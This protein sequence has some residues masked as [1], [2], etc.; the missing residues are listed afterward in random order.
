MTVRH[1]HVWVSCT[2]WPS[3][4]DSMLHLRSDMR[5]SLINRISL[6]YARP[7]AILVQLYIAHSLTT[8][9]CMLSSIDTLHIM[10]AQH[11]A[12]CAQCHAHPMP[13]T[14]H[15]MHIPCKRH[16]LVRRSLVMNPPHKVHL[17]DPIYT[18]W[19]FS[20]I[21][22]NA[23]PTTAFVVHLPGCP[24][25][26]SIQPNLMHVHSTSHPQVLHT[27]ALEPVT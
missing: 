23:G 21:S 22:A 4:K 24:G 7:N 27:C 2:L 12:F 14:S 11:T 19:N 25:P 20:L 9:L 16:A 18:R 17:A 10:P 15:A 13:C 3:L 26:L 6:L 8:K 5:R 1:T